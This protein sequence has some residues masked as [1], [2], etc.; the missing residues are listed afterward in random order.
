MKQNKTVFGDCGQHSSIFSLHE[1]R[2]GAEGQGLVAAV[3]LPSL[4]PHLHPKTLPNFS[5]LPNHHLPPGGQLTCEV[6]LSVLQHNFHKPYP[7]F[8]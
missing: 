6:K 4:V 3:A 1:E 8:Q 2:T 5:V 7:R